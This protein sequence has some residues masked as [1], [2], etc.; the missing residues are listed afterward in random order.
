M[1]NFLAIFCALILPTFLKQQYRVDIFCYEANLKFTLILHVDQDNQ[2][3]YFHEGDK[4]TSYR[5]TKQKAKEAEEGRDLEIHQ[6]ELLYDNDQFII[7]PYDKKWINGY[8]QRC[9]TSASNWVREDVFV[10]KTLL[11]FNKVNISAQ[12]LEENFEKY[13]N[14]FEGKVNVES[15]KKK[16]LAFLN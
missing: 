7:I 1:K 11:G 15:D 4:D 9:A 3:K 6:I 14:V 12:K 16:S 13:E 2:V 8:T 5:S 10:L